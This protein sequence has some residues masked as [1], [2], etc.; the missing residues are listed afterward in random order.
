MQE[1]GLGLT[2][3]VEV[4]EGSG[5]DA[6]SAVHNHLGLSV[7]R[8]ETLQGECHARTPMCQVH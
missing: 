4:W 3:V 5:Q 1:Q 6:H 7:Q 8:V 2:G